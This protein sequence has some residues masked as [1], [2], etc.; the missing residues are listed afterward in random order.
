MRTQ[1]VPATRLTQ[2][3]PQHHA[4]TTPH[5][6]TLTHTKHAHAHIHPLSIMADPTREN[7]MLEASTSVTHA[8]PATTSTSMATTSLQ[9]GEQEEQ[10]ALP[11]AT[12]APPSLET[13]THTE[14]DV[15]MNTTVSPQLTEERT[16]A[17]HDSQPPT[18]PPYIAIRNVGSQVR[19]SLGSAR[20]VCCTYV[21][22]CVCVFVRSYVCMCVCIRSCVHS[23]VCV[24]VFARVWSCV[25]VCVFAGC[26][27]E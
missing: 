4:H 21:C 9:E 6:H 14:A 26:V 27:S 18:D 8:F 3:R 5:T 24:Y 17:T 15:S 25:C 11:P 13:Q 1:P 22:V 16:T 20:L 10:Q 23:R 19:E 12:T 7:E 2:Y